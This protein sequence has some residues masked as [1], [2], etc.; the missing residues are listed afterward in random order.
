[1]DGVKNHE[2]TKVGS[3]LGSAKLVNTTPI[4]LWFMV[5]IKIGFMGFISKTCICTHM[6][7]HVYVHICTHMYIYIHK[8][9]YIYIYNICVY[10]YTCIYIYIHVRIHY[11]REF[12]SLYYIIYIYTYARKK[13]PGP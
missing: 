11:M 7:K 13:A 1:M 12:I 5:P 6:Y 9:V 8:C 4:S 10:I 3:P 2:K